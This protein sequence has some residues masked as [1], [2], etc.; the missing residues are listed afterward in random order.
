MAPIFAFYITHFDPHYVIKGQ[1]VICFLLFIMVVAWL[2]AGTAVKFLC[3]NLYYST[4][5]AVHQYWIA[6][7]GEKHWSEWYT[8][9]A[10][11]WSLDYPPAFAVFQLLLYWLLSGTSKVISLLP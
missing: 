2:L 9:E 1:I 4:D 11:E 10:S 6:L 8:D 3:F 5:L 7:T